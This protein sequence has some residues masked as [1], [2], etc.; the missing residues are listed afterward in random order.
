MAV[1]LVGVALQIFA[2]MTLPDG[3]FGPTP[4]WAVMLPPLLWIASDVFC[5]VLAV[6][7]IVVIKTVPWLVYASAVVCAAGT[8][9]SIQ[10]TNSY[11]AVA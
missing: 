3:V 6:H 11:L 1:T 9:V 10:L 2:A 7:Q 5:V 4:W 8:V